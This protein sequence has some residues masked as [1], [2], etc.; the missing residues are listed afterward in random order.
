MTNLEMELDREIK[1]LNRP[2]VEEFHA[3]QNPGKRLL[4]TMVLGILLVVGGYK[5]VQYVR[6]EEAMSRVMSNVMEDPQAPQMIAGLE[7][8]KTVCKTDV[9]PMVQDV[10]NRYKKARPSEFGRAYND[11]SS[12]LNNGFAMMLM[13]IACKALEFQMNQIVAELEKRGF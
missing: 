3:T 8:I 4:V 6:Y 5:A 10:V 13:P 2:S 12:K 11:T 7:F 1:K 9:P